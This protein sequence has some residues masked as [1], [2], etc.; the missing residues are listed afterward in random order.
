M[1]KF[2]TNIRRFIHFITVDIWRIP[3]EE[4]PKRKSFLYRQLRIILLAYRGF[5][6][7]RV[8]LRASALTYFTMLSIVPVLA[9]I[10]GIARGF[11]IESLIQEELMKN[12]EGQR[13][14]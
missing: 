14:I 6:E 9:L 5:K 7:D 8:Q 3:L 13:E 10:F 4:L 1:K 12:F 2:N 11:G